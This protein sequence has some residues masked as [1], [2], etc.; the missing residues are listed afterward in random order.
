VADTDGDGVIDGGEL[1]DT[2]TDHL[3]WND[4]SADA[5]TQSDA[6]EAT[7]AP[8]QSIEQKSEM[9][10]LGQESSENLS[11]TNGDAAALGTGN[12]SAA[13]GNVTRGGVPVSGASLLGPDGKYS[14]TET[15]PPKVSVSGTTSTPPVIEPAPGNESAPE[16][17]V[18][19]VE[20]TEPVVADT[21][22]ASE[23]DLDADNYADALELEIGLDPAN[24]DTDAD[25]VA[26]G[27]EVTIYFTDPFTL[28]TDGDNLS[29]GQ[30]LFDIRTDPLVSD[31]S[32]DGV[33]NA[34]ELPA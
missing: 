30:E 23:T 15:S 7:S 14:V 20:T 26:D 27:D 34:E 31:T 28:D 5:N 9:A 13:P 29:D 21:T 16:A 3:V 18:E 17:V 6:Q 24:P 4:F 25:G 8:V 2:R 10:T 32:G 1:Y 12:A 11:A 33:S 22:V 19:T